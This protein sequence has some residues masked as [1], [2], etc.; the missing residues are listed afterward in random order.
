M[1]NFLP[2][3][4]ALKH[5]IDALRDRC[6]PYLDPTG[7]IYRIRKLQHEASTA[8]PEPPPP[9]VFDLDRYRHL[10]THGTDPEAA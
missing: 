10:H 2:T 5:E 4:D 9:V 7:A 3:S 6:R 8:R 1:I